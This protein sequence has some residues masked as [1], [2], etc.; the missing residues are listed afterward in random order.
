MPKKVLTCDTIV[1][2][3]VALLDEGGV[4]GLSMRKLADRLGVITTGSSDYHGTGKVDHDLGCNT[5]SPEALAEIQR[6][7][8]S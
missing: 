5:T 1:A 2:A 7:I 8:R 3:A 4:E 6:R